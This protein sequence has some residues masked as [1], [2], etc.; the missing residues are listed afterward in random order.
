VVGELLANN[1]EDRNGTKRTSYEVRAMNV[2]F[3]SPPQKANEEIRGIGEDF[4]SEAEIEPFSFDSQNMENAL[5][6]LEDISPE[7]N[8]DVAPF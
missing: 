8:N 6:E 3:L 7:G 2:Q 1:W 4:S 5:G